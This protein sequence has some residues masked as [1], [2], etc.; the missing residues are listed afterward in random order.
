MVFVGGSV[1][2]SGV[3]TGAP[4]FTAEAVRYAVAALLLVL[5]ARCSGRRPIVRPLGAEWLWL[6]GI[7]AARLVLFKGGPG[8]GAPPRGAGGARGGGGLR[9]AVAGGGR[10]AAGAVPAPA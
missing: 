4:F 6:A 3:L 2:V 5:F 7:P 8:P 9:A 10:P 1:A